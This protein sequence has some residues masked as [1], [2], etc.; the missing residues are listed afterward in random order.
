MPLDKKALKAKLLAQY[1][2]HLDDVLD[3]I[4]ENHRFH[5]TEIEEIALDVRQEVGKDVTT[6]LTHGASQHREVDVA[7]PDCHQRMRAKGT[8]QKW[9]KTRTG[10]VQIARPYY[11]CE[12][13]GK[14]HFPPR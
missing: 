7:C 6:A 11:Y 4:D 14:G 12:A 5:S 1:Q 13:C 8:K 9:V 2:A 3:E 10:T